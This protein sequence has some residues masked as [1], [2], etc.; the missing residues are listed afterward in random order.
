MASNLF[1]TRQR[2]ALLP[3]L[4]SLSWKAYKEG[5][6]VYAPLLYYYQ[7]DSVVRDMGTQLMIGEYLMGTVPDTYNGMQRRVYLPRG[8]WYNWHDQTRTVSRGQYVKVPYFR[9]DIFTLPLFAREGAIIP[10]A[11]VDGETMNALGM[12]LDGS[13]RP[14]LLLRIFPSAV[15]TSFTCYDDDGQTIGYLRGEFA[16]TVVTQRLEEG[17]VRVTIGGTTGSYRQMTASYH[18]VTARNTMVELVYPTPVRGVV[19]NGRELPQFREIGDFDAA[20]EGF[21]DLPDNR[22]R[23]KTGVQDITR[24]KTLWFE[25]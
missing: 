6:C 11:V 2:Y 12:R 21:I 5:E 9:K 16:E 7:D 19:V 23:C 24:L 18:P 10:M 3:Y 8:V 15:A 4:Y 14:D 13:V 20:E 17:G 25:F 1:A 22:I